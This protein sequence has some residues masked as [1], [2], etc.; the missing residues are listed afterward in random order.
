MYLRRKKKV[1]RPWPVTIYYDDREQHPFELDED[2]FRLVRKRLKTGDYT[3]KGYEGVLCIEKKANI[4]EVL[5]NIC[6][7]DRERFTKFLERMSEFKYKYFIIEDSPD[8]VLKVLK[9]IP[10]CRMSPRTF[11]FWVNR[12][13]VDYGIPVIFTGHKPHVS[14]AM[15]DEL[16][17]RIIEKDLK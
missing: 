11:Y 8:R 16:F 10:D 17:T 12:I 7:S 15:I 2:K 13:V 14:K 1:K 6:R 4:R 5:I 9:G 3:M